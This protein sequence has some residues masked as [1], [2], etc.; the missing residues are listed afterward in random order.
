MNTPYGIQFFV[1]DVSVILLMLLVVG[2]AVAVVHLWRRSREQRK[3]YRE[4]EKTVD[5]LLKIENGA[6]GGIDGWEMALQDK[7]D[8]AAQR[9]GK[10]K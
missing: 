9:A 3:Q 10:R 2:L 5:R 1:L 4:I 8:R 7:K 6:G